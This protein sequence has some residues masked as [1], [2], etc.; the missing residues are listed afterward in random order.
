MACIA[1]LA[2]TSLRDA[3][4]LL[5]LRAIQTQGTGTSGRAPSLPLNV[6]AGHLALEPKVTT[7]VR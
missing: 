4:S 7:V 1:L 3:V 5:W 2:E 6:K